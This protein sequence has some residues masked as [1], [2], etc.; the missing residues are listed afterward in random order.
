[1]IIFGFKGRV[2]DRGEA[3]PAACPRCHNQTFFHYVSRQRWFSLFFVPV[4][5]ISSKHFLMC[6]VCSFGLALDA[7]GQQ[8][9]GHMAELT[10]QWRAGALSEESYRSSVEA[11]RQG[12]LGGSLPAL[13]TAGAPASPPIPPPPS[14]P[15]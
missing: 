15:Q 12:Q 1:M 3:V 7:E 11:F 5:P 14:A 6:P 2:K 4:I 9:A 8:R 10:G 13:P